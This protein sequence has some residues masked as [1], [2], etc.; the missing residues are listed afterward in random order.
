MCFVVTSPA[1]AD[2]GALIRTTSD[3]LRD[4]AS[5]I[6]ARVTD[7]R[8]TFD[9][10]AGPRTVVTLGDIHTIAGED[11]GREVQLATL[12]GPLPNRRLLVVSELAHFRRDSRYIVFLTSSDWFFSPVVADYAFRIENVAGR[13]VLVTQSGNP[14]VGV[15][16]FGIQVGGLSLEPGARQMRTR[17][18]RIALVEDAAVRAERALS[19]ADF[20]GTLKRLSA[21]AAPRGS[22]KRSMVPGRV[23]N[24]M[25][26]DPGQEGPR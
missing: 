19:H 1:R 18:D 3:A 24:V 5:V 13:E 17:F 7:I 4:A 14:I 15:N 2:S 6:E 12:G 25:R 26:V 20:V 16:E 22:F 9:P 10:V 23:W 8:F 11:P 21:T